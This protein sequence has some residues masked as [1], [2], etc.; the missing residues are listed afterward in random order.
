MRTAGR[1]AG[2]QVDACCADILG[3]G[4]K[5]TPLAVGPASLEEA[6]GF[7]AALGAW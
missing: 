6:G 7:Q 3:I 2:M 5:V 4:D 1:Q